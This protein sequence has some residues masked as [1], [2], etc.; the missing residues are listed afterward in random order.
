MA[1]GLCSGCGRG[2][3]RTGRSHMRHHNSTCRM[4]AWRMR[5]YEHTAERP[6]GPRQPRPRF[7]RSPALLRLAS[8][9]QRRAQQA[10]QS[11]QELQRQV[12][13]QAQENT[14]LRDENAELRRQIEAMRNGQTAGAGQQSE[15]GPQRPETG[16]PRR[17]PRPPGAS[18]NR[19]IQDLESQL[20]N[21][22]QMYRE[23]SAFTQELRAIHDAE[24]R[25]GTDREQLLAEAL[26]LAIEREPPLSGEWS[27][28]SAAHVQRRAALLT[29]ENEQLRRT[30][31]EVSAERQRLS[32][33]LLSILLP[34]QA[35][36]HASGV[37]YDVE[38]DPLIPQKREELILL[39]RYALWQSQH[40]GA[41]RARRIDQN[42]TLDE[43][44]LEAA[45]SARWRLI[46][47]P[48]VRLRR[49]G[50]HP[51]WISIGF[52]LDPESER[53]LMQQ[54]RLLMADREQRMR[55]TANTA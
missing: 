31:A 50:H 7:H 16:T 40:M 29:T 32:T 52:C 44:A 14:T 49:D 5:A 1:V 3:P 48:P 23:L 8:Q 9:H 2:L 15:A 37:N 53:F 21:C 46:V 51:R 12:A 18:R 36:T 27:A 54:S 26:A 33:R 28:E 24:L 41:V 47:Q 22:Q 17:P 30:I 19:P 55:G 25:R 38:S 13:A 6:P 10:E 20:R 34:G 45:L 39:D 42:K 43:Q 35:R 11:N 4:R